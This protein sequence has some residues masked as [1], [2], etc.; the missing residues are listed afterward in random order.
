LEELQGARK[1]LIV[2]AD[3]FGLT[4]KVNQAIIKGH[5]EGIITSTSLLANGR[6]FD[7]AVV[8]A[9]QFTSLGVGVHLNLTEG[10][11]LSAPLGLQGLVN[12]AGS[13]RLTP[14]RLA[15]CLL[16]GAIRLSSLE[17]ELRAQIERSL[18][19]GIRPTHLDSHKHI[20][21]F[22]AIFRVVMRLA[23][24]YGI[25]GI[26]CVREK[27]AHL[28]RL[29]RR[30]RESLPRIL[31][32]YLVGYTLSLLCMAQRPKLRLTRLRFPAYCFGITPTGF[33]DSTHFQEILECLPEGSTELICHPGTVDEDLQRSPTR[34]LEHRERELQ[35]ILAFET[36]ETLVRQGIRL[37]SYAG[38]D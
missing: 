34:L 2:N 7:S 29:V 17:G 18:D 22:P 27:V 10:V 37:I 31:K 8:L 9:K 32:Q 19:A 20:H 30:N 12:P 14:V 11:P 28:G 13:F 33:L 6:A 25:S 38:L 16:S 1:K 35:A 5:R 36:K 26:R 3:D 23:V 21:L 4:E 24:E 15:R